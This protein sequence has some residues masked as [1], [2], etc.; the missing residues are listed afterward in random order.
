[1][2]GVGIN[3]HHRALSFVK[4]WELRALTEELDA[5]SLVIAVFPSGDASA[6]TKH[7]RSAFRALCVDRRPQQ[8]HRRRQ[9]RGGKCQIRSDRTVEPPLFTKQGSQ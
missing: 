6:P 8:D 4:V 7:E 2:C 3:P 5:H 9:A 1:M